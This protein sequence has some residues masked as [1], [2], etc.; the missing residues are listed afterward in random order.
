MTSSAP[1]EVAVAWRSLLTHAGEITWT[2]DEGGNLLSITYGP[3]VRAHASAADVIGASGFDFVH[4][5]DLASVQAAWADITA[6]TGKSATLECRILVPGG[7]WRWMRHIV[8]DLRQTAHVG[9]LVGS[10]VDVTEQHLH[11]QELGLYSAA[12]RARFEQSRLPQA[13]VDLNGHISSVNQSFCELTGRS[14]EDLINR[15]VSRLGWSGDDRLTDAL[16]ADI[17]AGAQDFMQCEFVLAGPDRSSTPVAVDITT[18]RDAQGMPFGAA[19]FLHD[20]TSANVRDRALSE[21]EARYRT[22][23]E[24]AAEGIWAVSSAGTTLYANARMAAIMGVPLERLYDEPATTLFDPVSTS[25]LTAR[26]GASAVGGTERYELGFR[27]PD[28]DDRRVQV[29]ATPLPGPDGSIIGSLAMVSDVT[30]ARQ[31]E[32]ELRHAALHDA[33]T[34]LPNRTLFVDR[35]EHRLLRQDESTAVLFIDLDQFKLVND[36]RGHAV[37]DA[38]LVEVGQRLLSAIRPHDTVARFGG[39]EFVVLLEGVDERHAQDVAEDLLA[40]LAAPIQIGAAPVYIG[41]SVGI[42]MSPAATASD[43]LRY[44]DTALYAAKAAGRG[45]VR[46]FDASMADEA[47]TRYAL[48]T[49]LRV[50]LTNRALTM[51]FQ[52]IIDLQSGQVL[53]MEALARWNHPQLGP[54]P[55]ERFVGIA[56]VIGL[57]PDLD[58]W[59]VAYALEEARALQRRGVIPPAAYVSINLSASNVSDRGLEDFIVTSTTTAGLTPAH[60]VLEIT[61]SAIMRDVELAISLLRRLRVRGFR[62]ALDDFGTGHSSL[63]YLRDLPISILKIDRTFVAGIKED[64]DALAVV[65]SIVDLGRAVGMTVIA[66]GVENTLQAELLRRL[67]CQAAQGWLWCAAVPPEAVLAAGRWTSGFDVGP[68]VQPANSTRRPARA[69]VRSEHGLDRLLDMH[70]KGASLA[71]IAAALNADGYLTPG[72][73]HWH[74]TSVARAVSDAAYPQL[75]PPGRPSS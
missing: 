26:L 22:I 47:E 62:L 6:A 52:P 1:T 44:A 42:A 28:G 34:G 36:S 65:A 54:I 21:S 60:V 59:A 14:S 51:D 53:G 33:L 58:R 63:A 48:G 8:T 55:P 17:L 46:M 72:G 9:A 25:Q 35:L 64:S 74:R 15:P 23:A 31:L 12:F 19:I 71:T 40:A 4:P 27:H 61:E 41:A 11:T 50:A 70:R 7:E 2:A 66:E 30:E 73:L 56:E 67:G 49:D 69:S 75:T 32:Q 20:L 13:I 3:G 68:H 24:T 38:M 43:L 57:A 29:A 16:M 18:M 37:G 10:S 45:R 5:E 39:D